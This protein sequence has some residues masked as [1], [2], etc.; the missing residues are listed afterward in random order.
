[1]YTNV[2]ND[3]AFERDVLE[4]IGQSWNSRVAVRKERLD[5]SDYY[6]TT[7]P[8]F[9]IAMVPFWNDPDFSG[10]DQNVKQRLLAAAWVAY[11]EKAMYLEDEIVLPACNLMLKGRM[12]GVS[13]PLV[14]QVL[15]QVQV[16]EQFHML[17]CLDVCN[18]ARKH[19]QLYDFVALV[20]SLGARLNL[21]LAET[22]TASRAQLFRLAYASVAEM[23]INAYLTQV[24]KDAA[25]QPINRIN[26]DMHRR[27]ESVHSIAFH[28]IVASVYTGLEPP[29][30][31]DFRDCL[32]DAL[33]IF[34]SPD[35][36]FWESILDYMEINNRERIISRLRDKAI[37][38]RLSRDY[39][40]LQSLCQKVGISDISDIQAL[41]Q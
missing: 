33:Q 8:D 35:I 19:H 20:P 39:T 6:K 4:R 1:M 38:T 21:H 14:K 40:A 13:D 5:L 27:D 22:R 15:A 9:P 17:M 31:A 25:I 34:S 2:N 41:L 28:E 23:S 36:A 7:L 3:A 29:D 10:V 37:G 32:A 12:P 18:V 30:Q 16:D 26:T 11:N 24:S